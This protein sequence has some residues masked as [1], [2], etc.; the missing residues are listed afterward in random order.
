MTNSEITKLREKLEKLSKE[1][2]IIEYISIMNNFNNK[3]NKLKESEELIENAPI[4]ILR[5]SSDGKILYE[6]PKLKE[7]LGLT[8][9]QNSDAIGWNVTEME[10]VFNTG[11][12]NNINELLQG[13]QFKDFE[14]SFQSIYG[15]NTILCI[16]GVPLIDKKGRVD[17][18]LLLIEDITERKKAEEG[19]TKSEE[20][21][22]SIL[23]SMED[24][25]FV[26]DNDGIFKWYYNPQTNNL[27][28]PPEQFIGK[29]IR[30]VLPKD[31][32][33]LALDAI[34]KLKVSGRTQQF[35]YPL[36]IKDKD[37]WF[38]AR[39]SSITDKGRGISGFTIVTR[40]ITD[41]KRMEIQ[42]KEHSQKL[43][44]RVQ[45]RTKEVELEKEKYKNLFEDSNDPIYL[46][47]PETNNILDCNY[48]AK[49]M[50][51]CF[52]KKFYEI[53]LKEDKD[54]VLRSLK[55][56][57]ENIDTN[58]KSIIKSGT[59]RE[60]IY[61]ETHLTLIEYGTEKIIQAICRDITQI[62]RVENEI[63]N[64]ML[65]YNVDKGLVYLIEEPV[66]DKSLDVFN[67]LL[68]CGFNGYIFSRTI[69]EIINKN[70]EKNIDVFWLAE[71]KVDVN[72]ISPIIKEI[73]NKIEN[74]PRCS[75]VLLI[76]R[77]DYLKS[78]NKF[79]DIMEFIQRLVEF[80]YIQK[81]IVLIS[82][83]P[84]ILKK[85]ELILLKKETNKVE[86]KKK[87]DLEKKIITLLNYVN[88]K[89]RIGITPSINEIGVHFKIT[90]KTARKRLTILENRS[91]IKVMNVGRQKL[92]EITEKGKENI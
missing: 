25:V 87:L 54:I 61:F 30:D 38:E 92:I 6:N 45:D 49:K 41:R 43:E 22:R 46:I 2:I 73:E 64:K 82:V 89:N 62:I 29:N 8:K 85:D 7:I 53:Y 52:N 71:K 84:K 48:K 88:E 40:N 34:N 9:D 3:I 59:D 60:S 80:V 69:P 31:V 47:D 20:N 28:V 15:K 12:I 17:N 32:V 5:L 44:K 18:A 35:E 67:N 76:D 37:S 36:K 4:G 33:E 78:K 65:K 24:L 72:T 11:I 90:R 26:I 19:L 16:S 13:K 77:I 56:A 42:I 27:Y 91:F 39:I 70:N 51:K 68:E 58:F 79:P 81:W 66:L 63:M 21:L 50:E 10:N 14:C 86:P 75:N 74:L 23:K 83:D 1:E 55:K 57:Y